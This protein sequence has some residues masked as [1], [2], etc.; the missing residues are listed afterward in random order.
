MQRHEHFYFAYKQNKRET[1]TI[2]AE[3][4]FKNIATIATN[5]LISTKRFGNFFGRD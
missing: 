2:A 5:V 4:S 3:N 1:D